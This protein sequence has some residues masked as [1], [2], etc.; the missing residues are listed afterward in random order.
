MKLKRYILYIVG[1]LLLFP[2]AKAAEPLTENEDARLQTL[3][4]DLHPAVYLDNL[5]LKV[6]GDNP[7]VL[8]VDAASIKMLVEAQE[9]FE[10]VE[11]ITLKLRS[12]KE[13]SA[14]INVSQLKAF[15]NLKYV[16]VQYEYDACSGGSDT[17]L[18]K[19]ADAAV[20]LPTD[21]NVEVLYQLSIP[22]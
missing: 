20:A 13:E 19:K 8:Y 22:Q 1:M 14:K 3:V 6:Y 9:T 11:L 12:A 21:S 7:V 10:D 2:V 15:T 18:D 4:R 5:E 17:C 16:L